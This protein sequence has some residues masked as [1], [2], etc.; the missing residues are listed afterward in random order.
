MCVEQIFISNGGSGQLGNSEEFPASFSMVF[1]LRCKCL[2]RRFLVKI[3]NNGND[4]VVQLASFWKQHT[5]GGGRPS[6]FS[7]MFFSESK[8]WAAPLLSIYSKHLLDKYSK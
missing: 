6:A 2:T 4:D 3:I 1:S 7:D 5:N 8:F